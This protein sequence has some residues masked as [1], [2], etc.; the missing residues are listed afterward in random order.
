[1]STPTAAETF[2][3]LDDLDPATPGD[4]FTRLRYSYGQLLGA[5]D[6]TTE[7]R[8]F[9]LRSRLHNAALHGFGTVWGLKVGSQENETTL[10]LTCDTGLAIDPL[11]REVYVPQKVC[12]DITGLATTRF[13][14]DLA[15]PP[16][17]PGVEVTGDNPRRRVYVVLRY[18]ACLTEQVPAITQPCAGQD[19]GLAPSRVQD[20]YRLCLEAAPPDLTGLPVR[21]ITTRVN[22]PADFRTR[23]LE[24]I[25]NPDTPPPARLWSGAD[26]APLLLAVLDLEP[27]GNPVERVKLFGTIDNSVR[28]L[29]PAVQT[30]ADLALGIRLEAAG[31]PSPF[32]VGKLQ[33]R[34]GEGA[35]AAR[36]F[37][38][39]ITTR[40]LMPASLGPGSV[41]VLRF[42]EANQK[43]Q[44]VAI[45]GQT[46]SAT[47]LALVVDEVLQ[48]GAPIQVCLLGTGAEAIL[49]MGGQ[50]LAGAIGEVVPP[51]T[52]RDACLF[53]IHP[54]TA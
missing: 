52:G 34:A 42:D 39:L 20:G 5:E 3:P 48:A 35:D 15:A 46:P 4:P 26:D 44:P 36:S 13:W 8:Y 50:P 31:A 14:A 18:R 27:V 53:A 49:D 41:R 2:I 16:P 22:P 47:G 38:D 7:Q 29:L 25:I 1:M 10:T 21:D 40:P 19:A 28:A 24:H 12:L 6:F 9:L 32:Q 54:T 17:A 43:W 23:L 33:S 11:G 37:I 30:V 45:A 51:G